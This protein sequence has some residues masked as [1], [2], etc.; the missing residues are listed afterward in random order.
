MHVVWSYHEIVWYWVFGCLWF[1]ALFGLIPS[2]Q[3]LYLWPEI[4]YKVLKL[5]QIKTWPDALF[6]SVS[7]DWTM[8]LLR[9][10]QC[11]LFEREEKKWKSSYCFQKYWILSKTSTCKQFVSQEI[12]LSGR[13]QRDSS[14]VFAVSA[15]RAVL[16]CKVLDQPGVFIRCRN[17]LLLPQEVC[18]HVPNYTEFLVEHLGQIYITQLTDI[19]MNNFS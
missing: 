19:R 14:T 13:K 5:D 17:N 2:K 7:L 4:F 1:R 12:L 18:M 6:V 15:C 11:L 8:S 9:K 16:G 3:S 10:P